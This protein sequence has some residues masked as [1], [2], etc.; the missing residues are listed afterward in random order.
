MGP[1]LS[2]VAPPDQVRPDP[3]L[4]W[5]QPHSWFCFVLADPFVVEKKEDSGVACRRQI[6]VDGGMIAGLDLCAY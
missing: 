6:G 2:D 4:G 5:H 1:T 3:S